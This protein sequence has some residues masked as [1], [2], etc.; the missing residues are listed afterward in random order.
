MTRTGNTS[1]TRSIAERAFDVL[2]RNEVTVGQIAPWLLPLPDA[3][4]LVL[5][6]GALRARLSDPEDGVGVTVEDLGDA[7]CSGAGT[8]DDPVA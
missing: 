7:L 2:P 6:D 1:I 4:R 8:R 3:R 5:I